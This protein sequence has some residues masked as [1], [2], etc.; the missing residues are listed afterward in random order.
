MFNI[1]FF[2]QAI[3]LGIA[4]AMDCFTVSITCGLQK[5]MSKSRT[6]LLAFCFAFFQ[7]FMPL[8]GSVLTSFFYSFIE[9]IS[10]WIS[11]SLLFI[12][13]IKMFIDGKNF[14]LRD[15]VFDVSSF[16][17]IILLSIATSI[18]ALVIGISFSGMNWVVGQQ[19][20]SIFIIFLVT[21]ILSLLGVKMGERINFVKPRFALILGGFIL[22]L[23]G[24]KTILQH[25]IQA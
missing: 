5:S 6:L 1:G 15:K 3:A 10:A 18:D 2:I 11:F 25:Y 13:G 14:R 19:L 21:L 7:A 20:M 12:I 16:R 22:I 17:V 9:T 24:V 4:L 23:I 8:L